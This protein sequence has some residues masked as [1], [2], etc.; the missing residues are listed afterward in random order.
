KLGMVPVE[1]GA[2]G[3]FDATAMALKAGDLR[4]FATLQ[5]R[6]QCLERLQ[7]HGA[8]NTLRA[9]AH[10]EIDVVRPELVVTGLASAGQGHATAASVNIMLQ[11]SR[12]QAQQQIG[13]VYLG[14]EPTSSPCQ[15]RNRTHHWPAPRRTQPAPS[16][17]HGAE[18]AAA[19][20]CAWSPDPLHQRQAER[21][22]TSRQPHDCAERTIAVRAS[23]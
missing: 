23:M 20:P 4:C 10:E 8:T 1:F 12:L 15:R 11:F 14:R 6:F 16:R 17:P 5:V 7:R 21:S 9:V 19:S 3:A 13:E 2:C 18:T 22:G